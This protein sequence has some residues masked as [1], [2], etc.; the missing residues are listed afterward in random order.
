MRVGDSYR[1]FLQGERVAWRAFGAGT[2]G[3]AGVRSAA[4]A[5]FR[6]LTSPSRYPEYQAFFELLKGTSG[7]VLDVGSPK[8]FSVLLASRER[9]TVVATDIWPPA[10]AEAE[11]L[12]GGLPRGASS[13]LVLGVADIREP[14]PLSLLPPD[15]RFDAAFSMSVIEHIEPDPGGDVIALQRIAEVV[16]PGGTVVVSVPVSARAR[17]DY[18]RSEMYGRKAE[19]A[20]GAF[21]QRVYDSTALRQLCASETPQMTLESC[22]LITWPDH[23]LMRLQPMFPVAIGFAGFAFPL[24]AGGFTTTAPTESIQEIERDGDAILKFRVGRSAG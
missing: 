4:G 2:I 7:W 18:L 14:L 5:F 8:L 23:L 10:I 12:R 24:F 21:F 22:R 17:S 19:D 3:K 20:R 6:P 16:R 13:R 9:A 11:A 1:L 15:G